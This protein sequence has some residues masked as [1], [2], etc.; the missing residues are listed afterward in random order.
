[1]KIAELI[2]QTER[3]LDALRQAHADL[4]K[5]MSRLEIRLEAFREVESAGVRSATGQTA[6]P[7]G[8]RV[9]KRIRLIDKD[10]T[11]AQR[12][13]DFVKANPNTTTADIANK[14]ESVVEARGP[15]GPRKVIG[16]AVFDLKR[17]GK[18]IGEPGPDGVP[19]LTVAEL[20]S[21]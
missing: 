14:L 16:D 18:L 6:V 10:V 21:T 12:I 1:M 9:I 4:K 3:E 17:R 7:L 15:K 8:M 11:T 19:R 20:E 2:E 5:K 13:M